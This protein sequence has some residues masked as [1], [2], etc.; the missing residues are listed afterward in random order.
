MVT[1]SAFTFRPST[2]GSQSRPAS[3]AT[4]TSRMTAHRKRIE[5]RFIGGT[6]IGRW[7]A[8]I[9]PPGFIVGQYIVIVRQ[10]GRASALRQAPS[11]PPLAVRCADPQAVAI[12]VA[13]LDLA[14]PRRVLRAGA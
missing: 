3:A 9:L 10:W 14:R 5:P 11:R 4:P 13:Q 7:T 6:S 2:C 1:W 8:H 12:G